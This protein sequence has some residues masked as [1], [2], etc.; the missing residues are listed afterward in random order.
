MCRRNC[1]AAHPSQLCR[2][3]HKWEFGAE[4]S[5][6]TS[7]TFRRAAMLRNRRGF[8]DSLRAERKCGREPHERLASAYGFDVERC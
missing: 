8:C 4:S 3:R 7:P 2:V 1:W 6:Q 5:R